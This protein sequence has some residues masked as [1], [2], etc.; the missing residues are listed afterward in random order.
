[1]LNLQG[2]SVKDRIF[3]GI[4]SSV[5]SNAISL[6][7]SILLV[8]F[9]INAWGVNLY[10][11][12]LVI[13]AAIVYLGHCDFGM[14]SYL[15]NLLAI[16]HA[17]K[18]E[19]S[20]V[21]RMSEGVSLFTFFCLA[22]LFIL[23]AILVLLGSIEVPGFGRPLYYWEAMVLGT[24]GFSHLIAIPSG[25]Y[26]SGYQA[27]GHF[28]RG[29]MIGNLIRLLGLMGSIFVLWLAFQPVDYAAWHLMVGVVGMLVPVIDLPRRVP[30]LR[31]IK[32][33]IINANKG[34][35]HLSGSIRFWVMSIAG[36]LKFQGVLLIMASLVSPV[37]VALFATHKTLANIAGCMAQ[38]IQGPITPEM[39]FLWAQK[40][41]SDLIRIQSLILKSIIFSSGI[42]AVFLWVLAPL[43]Y[44]GWTGGELRL[45][46]NLLAIFLAQAVLMAS[47]SALVFGMLATNQHRQLTLWLVA[48]AIITLGLAGLWV[49][50][51]GVKGV[52]TAGLVADFITS[53]LVFPFLTAG[54]LRVASLEVYKDIGLSFSALIP[55]V[56]LAYIS[57]EIF[58]GWVGLGVWGISAVPV[59]L[60]IARWLVGP[61]EVNI[62]L[63]VCLKVVGLKERSF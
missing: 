44:S 47:G 6:L 3:K 40:R 39:S 17:K 55:F 49:G 14:Q 25:V 18:D 51:Y 30:I 1:M 24:L 32:I 35:M 62:G 59:I 36:V 20:F 46:F 41:F 21:S 9:F 31:K 60:I 10:G 45:E 2:S 23:I 63:N 5:L 11:H 50:S 29:Q 22:L 13:T 37:L 38:L 43:V 53:I 61:E 48:N 15:A 8:P 7:Q 26:A 42:M 54:F 57:V 28:Y 12:W 16:A 27:T 4:G 19:K 33:N 52:A 56:G 34:K 58:D